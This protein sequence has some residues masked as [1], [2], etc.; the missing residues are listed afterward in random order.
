MRKYICILL[1]AAIFVGDSGCKKY[2]NVVP[3]DNLA[4]NNYWK[5]KGEVESFTL[6]VYNKLRT[7]TMDSARFF[8][9]TGDFR[10]APINTTSEHSSELWVN[11]LRTNDLVTLLQNS[12]YLKPE[13]TN[14][15]WEITEWN[16]L[17]TVVQ[18]ANVLYSEVGQMPAASLSAT[19]KKTYQAEAVFLRSL[20]YFLMVRVY[21]DVPYYTDAFNSTQLPRTKML[22]VLSNCYN[23]LAKVKDDLPWTY[24][25]ASKVAVRAMRGSA[26]ILM[27]HISMW[28]AGF[29]QANQQTYWTNTATLG[30]EIMTQNGGAYELLPIQE[31]YEIFRGGSKEGLFEIVQ[32]QTTAEQFFQP[33]VYT[34]FV[35]HK[36]YLTSV[37]SIVWYDV[38]F[39]EKIYPP[40][41]T[42]L[43]EQ[44][45]F[46]GN[47]YNSDGSQQMLKFINAAQGSISGINQVGNKIVFR[48]ADAILLTAE[49]LA[50]LGQSGPAQQ[51]VNMIRARAGA[52]PITTTGTD[53]QSDIYWERVRELMGE[54]HYFYD[55]VRTGK[56]IDGSYSYSPISLSDFN[57]GAWTWPIDRSA[58]NN[59]PLI[60]LNS[61]WNY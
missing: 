54:G 57:N 24:A 49:A 5:N 43:R 10:C 40:G 53:L 30:Q 36:P 38:N 31:S 41:V 7:A 4:G 14:R 26:I 51:D 20:A 16:N 34:S 58:L 60:T 15:F 48:Y 12:Q 28:E 27:M 42:D 17:F 47:I 39:M 59:D 19:D 11:Y 18:L 29:D 13:T 25:D 1:F 6:G 37:T 22:T 52:P 61:F 8:V 33:A 44:Y 9:A 55:L 23:D 21:G 32:N 56:A 46:D 2:L 35:L 50:D 45:W 3:L